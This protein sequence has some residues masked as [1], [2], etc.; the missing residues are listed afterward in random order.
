MP[1]IL[2]EA[3]NR[4]YAEIEVSEREMP[5]KRYLQGL[6]GVLNRLTEQGRS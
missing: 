1:M 3:G 2:V 6:S 4:G 5:R